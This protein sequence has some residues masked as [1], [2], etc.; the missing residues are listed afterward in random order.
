MHVRH[1]DC[2]LCLPGHRAQM[3]RV[4]FAG[5]ERFMPAPMRGKVRQGALDRHTRYRHRKRLK[6]LL[7]VA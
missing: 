3:T 5:P 2:S 1:C 4:Y 6:K 7:G